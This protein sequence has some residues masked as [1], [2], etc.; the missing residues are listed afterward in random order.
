MPT[1]DPMSSQKPVFAPGFPPGTGCVC[2]QG[3]C[4]LFQ[5]CFLGQDGGRWGRPTALPRAVRRQVRL[6]IPPGLTGETEAESA[7]LCLE[8]KRRVRRTRC[9][10]VPIPCCKHPARRSAAAP[11]ILQRTLPSHVHAESCTTASPAIAARA[12]R[13]EPARSR[14][15][16]T[17][18]LLPL[19]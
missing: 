5:L 14:A 10:R 2:S 6:T 19:F 8:R 12:P 3:C 11:S 13:S 15:D 1:H 18:H 9:R 4:C 17:W 7:L 16:L